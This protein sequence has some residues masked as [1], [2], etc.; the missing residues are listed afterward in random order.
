MKKRKVVFHQGKIWSH[1][2]V[3][4]VTKIQELHFEL[5]PRIRQISA[6]RFQKNP[7]GNSCCGQS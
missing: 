5:L 7:G 6:R 1:R 4:T 3:Q 2:S